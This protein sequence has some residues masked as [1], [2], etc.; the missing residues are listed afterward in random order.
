LRNLFGYYVDAVD[1]TVCYLNDG[2]TPEPVFVQA[3]RG[4]TV[5][6]KDILDS[7][8]ELAAHAE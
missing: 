3:G 7:M 8:K 6:R 2:V 4:Q 5:D 1:R